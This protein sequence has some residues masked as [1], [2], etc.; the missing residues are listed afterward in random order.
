MEDVYQLFLGKEVLVDLGRTVEL[1]RVARL[2]DWV[3]G[4]VVFM[5]VQLG[6]EMVQSLLM[7]L[8]VETRDVETLA[9]VFSYSARKGHQ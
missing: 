1:A 8:F 4:A 9:T 2:V 3:V 6:I 5:H 7:L